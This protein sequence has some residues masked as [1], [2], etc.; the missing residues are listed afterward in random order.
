MNDRPVNG[1]PYQR[2]TAVL[3]GKQPDRLP[4]VTRLEAWYKSHQRSGTLPFRLRDLTL[5][6][7]HQVTGAGQLKFMTPYALK[8]CGVEVTASFEGEL[9][10][11]EYEP[12]IENFPGMWD[13]VSTEKS[14]ETFTE[15]S[16]PV[17][18]LHLRHE[19]LPEGVFN[20]TDPYLKK[21]LI[22]SGAD[23]RPVEYILEHAEY[24]PQYEEIAAE[25][26]RLGETGF[27]VPLLHRIPFQQVLLEYLGEID[28]FYALHDESARV[29]RLLAILNAQLLEIIDQLAGFDWPY[30][31]FP[32]N[33]HGLMTNPRLFRDYCLPVYQEYTCRLHAQGKKAGS[34]TDGDVQPL[35]HL[36]AESGLDVC[37]SFSPSPLTGCPFEL[38]WEA[39]HGGPLIWGAIPS[40]LLEET[41][42]ET[43]FRRYVARLLETVGQGPVI[44]GVV[45][46]F[47]RHN[48]IERVETISRLIEEHTP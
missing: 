12:V 16:T 29:R 41:T 31:E 10:Y 8:L 44:F 46:L 13:L 32:D 43:D 24:V 15:L 37:E 33:L 28:L 38:A 1:S 34:H 3:N 17:G 36:L 2:I 27:V 21:H 5:T 25:Q 42:C 7:V 11:R 19:L 9:C 26:A 23:Y 14:G 35:L 6:E 39:W 4:F 40:P 47:L 45:D 20:G 22:G 30:V 48:S 18:K